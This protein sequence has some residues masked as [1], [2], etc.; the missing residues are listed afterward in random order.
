MHDPYTDEKMDTEFT[1]PIT[2]NDLAY[3]TN[4]YR[5]NISPHVHYFPSRLLMFKMMRACINIQSSNDLWFN[6]L[7]NKVGKNADTS[8]DK[9]KKFKENKGMANIKRS[10]TIKKKVNKSKDK[11]VVHKDHDDLEEK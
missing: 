5:E 10:I 11:I 1:I 2:D 8:K 6:K 9:R 4:A 7:E 3:P